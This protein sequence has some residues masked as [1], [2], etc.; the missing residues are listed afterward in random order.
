MKV[1]CVLSQRQVPRILVFSKENDDAVL[2]SLP[3]KV[4]SRRRF[5]HLGLFQMGLRGPLMTRR[6]FIPSIP[7]KWELGA[8]LGE[9][10][11]ADGST[12][13]LAFAGSAALPTISLKDDRL[14]YSSLST[15]LNIWRRDLLHPESPAVELIPSSRAQLDAQ[16]SP[17]GKHI[18]FNS[19]RS[20]LQGVWISSYDG[21]NLVQSRTLTMRV[22]VRNGRRTGTRSRLTRFPGTAG[23]YMWPTWP[24]GSLENSSRI[25]PTS[26]TS[27]VPRWEVD[28]F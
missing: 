26:S 6:S 8:E 10:T 13:R 2:Q 24:N 5:H 9:V 28:I 22:V 19:V 18:V 21:S 7:W 14:A 4:V 23:K 27:L 25:S 3:I 15:S 11:V 1:A 20:G 16:Y 12:K 17:D